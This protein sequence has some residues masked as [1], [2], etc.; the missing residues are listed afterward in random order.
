MREITP[1]ARIFT[2]Y[3]GKFGIPR[4]AGLVENESRVVFEPAFRDVNAVR[5]IEAF[6]H[7]WLIWE[8]SENLREGFSP[9][10][11]PPRLGGNERVGVFA[12][13]S[14]FRPN[15]L[16]LS[17]VRLLRVETDCPDAPVLVVQGADM[18][19]GTP[20]YD[21]KPYLPFADSVPNALAGFAGPVEHR[22]AEVIFDCGTLG[23]SPAVL[24]QLTEIL[25]Q[26][27]RPHYQND[28]GRVYA[29]EYAGVHVEFTGTADRI[30][31]KSLKGESND[32]K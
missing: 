25:A 26:D 28:P 2:P 3:P 16:A 30:A 4:Q 1:V 8:F 5:G 24:S 7:L 19:S 27:P 15:G 22:R 21:V 20:V 10:V 11:R 13:R 9:T 23:V 6:S 32:G 12:S 31:V 18:V 17:A 14:S 29:F